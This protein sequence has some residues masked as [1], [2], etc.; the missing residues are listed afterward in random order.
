VNPISAGLVKGAVPKKVFTYAAS[1]FSALNENVA[2][3][4]KTIAKIFFFR[5]LFSN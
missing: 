1:G 3:K 2:V 5:S 4:T